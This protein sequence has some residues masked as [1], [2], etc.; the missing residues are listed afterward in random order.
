MLIKLNELVML[1]NPDRPKLVDSIPSVQ[2]FFVGR[3]NELNCIFEKLTAN[4][5]LFV[6]GM[7]GIGK[8]ELVKV[9]ATR[10]RDEF[11][12]V[13]YTISSHTLED[14]V[15]DDNYLKISN[16]IRQPDEKTSE[17]ARR[18]LNKLKELVCPE[19]IFIIDN[20][21]DFQSELYEIIMAL[22]CNILF[23]TRKLAEEFSYS[24]VTIEP[25]KKGPLMEIFKKYYTRPL[26]ESDEKTVEEIIN[27]VNGH[28]MM[29][30]LIAK[31]MMKGRL[32]PEKMLEKMKQGVVDT[33]AKEHIV[34][35]KDNRISSE[36]IY[37]HLNTLFNLSEIEGT[38]LNILENLSLMP[39]GGVPVE[40][41]ASW[42]GLD[43]YDL[44]NELESEG[45]ISVDDESDTV[46]LHPIIAELVLKKENRSFAMLDTMLENLANVFD[47]DGLYK[48]PVREKETYVSTAAC[49]CSNLCRYNFESE[50]VAAF[51]D[52]TASDIS[53]F[54][55][56]E[57]RKIWIEKALKIRKELFGETHGDTA[58]SYGSFGVFYRSLGKFDL[59]EEFLLKALEIR[60]EIYGENYSDTATSYS[61]LGGLYRDLGKLDLAEEYYLKALDIRKT[62]YGDMYSDTAISYNSL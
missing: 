50:T 57:E 40:G 35:G 30:E 14:A 13:V 3:E 1:V 11:R 22:D 6:C 17:Y 56:L 12:R 20:F 42:C 9:F 29:V 39:V 28:T 19:D 52:D 15:V 51:L 32:N 27:Q 46:S 10:F 4:K 62:I 41:F 54:G 43:G 44:I 16:F 49:V 24:S 48:L 2:S 45:W 60:K 61:E 34:S 53:G 59:A 8:T 5:K 25:M 37:G 26:S 58:T 7:G 47:K 23:V 38:K 21:S 18:K 33:A 31:Q 36:T 55:Y